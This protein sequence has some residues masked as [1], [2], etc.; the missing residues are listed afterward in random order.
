MIPTVLDR[1][2]QKAHTPFQLLS[3][4]TE[5]I[6]RHLLQNPRETGK[7]ET[8]HQDEAQ[9]SLACISA[10]P[11]AASLKSHPSY[12]QVIRPKKTIQFHPNSVHADF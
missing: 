12:P 2:V 6:P 7:Y 4:R 11:R 1:F 8:Q 5:K 9:V 10:D 3:Y